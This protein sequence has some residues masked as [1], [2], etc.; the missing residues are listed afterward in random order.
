M[1]PS[2][3]APSSPRCLQDDPSVPGTTI[4]AVST[5]FL[6]RGAPPRC[7]SHGASSRAE[8]RPP[9]PGSRPAASKGHRTRPSTG[10]TRRRRPGRRLRR[11]GR[12]PSSSARDSGKA[13]V[14]PQLEGPSPRSPPAQRRQLECGAFCGRGPMRAPPARPARPSVLVKKVPKTWRGFPGG[15]GHGAGA[16]R[17]DQGLRGALSGD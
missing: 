5:A 3:P 7:R 6:P 17:R 1:P 11:S 9:G 14:A 12:T 15:R 8:S 4:T 2:S 10:A 13:C 16:G